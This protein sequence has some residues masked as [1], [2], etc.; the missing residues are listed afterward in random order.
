MRLR[1]LLAA[2]ALAGPALAQE[3]P[4]A[5][6]NAGMYFI[7]AE[8]AGDFASRAQGLMYR[9]QLASNAGMLFVFERPGEQCMW[10][11]NTLIPLSVAFMDEEGAIINIEDM[12]PQTLDSHCARRPA[13][14][15][16]EMNGGWFAAR[17][18]KP[19][20]RIGGIPG[21]AK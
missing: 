12:A 8:V 16:L 5:Q 7:R 2:F 19:G 9:K 18:I 15:A 20:T 10:M 6:L 14:Y 1:T 13:R 11:K 17:G 3:L 4:L 21:A